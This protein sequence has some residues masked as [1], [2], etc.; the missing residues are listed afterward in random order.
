MKIQEFLNIILYIMKKYFKIFGRDLFSYEIIKKSLIDIH[1][2]KLLYICIKM[3]DYYKWDYY[4]WK[5]VYK[6]IIEHRKEDFEIS[7]NKLKCFSMIIQDHILEMV[8]SNDDE[9]KYYLCSLI[10]S[11]IA[12][13][14]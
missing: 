13:Y 5:E 6:Y 4:K 8:N 7:K 2:L 9:K 14:L 1:E 10:N 11:K 12:K 3:I